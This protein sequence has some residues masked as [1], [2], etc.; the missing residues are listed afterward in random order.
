MFAHPVQRPIGRFFVD[1][2]KEE[3]A[4]PSEGSAKKSHLWASQPTNA[5][6]WSQTLE[7]FLNIENQA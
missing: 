1:R 4:L 5:P 7:N 2:E 3:K 6:E